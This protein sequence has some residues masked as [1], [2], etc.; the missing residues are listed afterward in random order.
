MVDSSR[1]LARAI[2]IATIAIAVAACSKDSTSSTS[3]SI[4]GHVTIN[5]GDARIPAENLVGAHRS[6]LLGALAS[7]RGKESLRINVIF[8]QEALGSGR[9]GAMSVRTMGRAREVADNIRARLAAHPSASQF[10]VSDVSPAIGA[11]RLRVRDASQ[12]DAVMAALRADPAVAS[13]DI[14][15]LVSRG[16]ETRVHLDAALK[17][18]LVREARASATAGAKGFRFAGAGL[19]RIQYWNYNIID[20]PRAWAVPDTGSAAVTVA[21]IDDGINLHPDIA[22]NLDLAGGYDFVSDD[23]QEFGPPVPNCSGGPAF[24]NSDGDGTLGPDSD[25][26]MPI[27]VTFDAQDGCFQVDNIANHGLHVSGTIGATNGSANLVTGVNW[28]VRI[29]MIRALGIDGFGFD[30]DIAQAVLYAAGLPAAGAGGL[31]V[32]APNRAPIINMSL[33]GES[34]STLGAAVAA[35]I[36]AGSVIIASA[37][38]D[39]AST[40]NFPASYPNVI[41]V[42]ALGADGEL[43]SYSTS[44]AFVSL[45]APGGDFRFDIPGAFAGG[46][47]GVLSTVW[48]FV[49]NP[50]F[51]EVAGPDYAFYTGTSMAAPHVSGVAALVLAANPGLTGQ[52]LSDRLTSTAVDMGPP[53]RD[54][55]YGFG[56]VDAYNAITGTQGPAMNVFVSAIDATTGEVA[57]TVQAGSDLSYKLDGLQAGSYY[58][59]AGQ[60]EDGDGVIGFPGRRYGWA[61]GGGV[62]VPVV[63]GANGAVEASIPIGLPVQQLG[64]DGRVFVGSWVYGAL[65]TP[66]AVET[67]VVTIPTSG[68]Y[69]FET[70]GAIGSCGFALELNTAITV[71]DAH[72]TLVGSN[73]NTSSTTGHMTFPGQLCSYVSAQLSPGT[74]TVEVKAGGGSAGG[75]D[76]FNPG[77]YRLQVRSG[78]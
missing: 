73:D 11:A 24:T 14:D 57:K 33:G 46:T 48:D 36:N 59:V 2:S 77:T 43:A 8:R 54:A 69:S 13:V 16:A 4:V 17:Q 51:N 34:D 26:T 65:G 47:S 9:L 32:M 67:Y 53:G 31:T 25:P 10:T 29:R 30:F 40:P 64:V 74:Y 42:A 27:S 7:R 50:L 60:D 23:S 78:A 3:R 68:V 39:G 55:R 41:S 22:P 20:A 66:T 52:Q 21:V 62:P 15:R 70:S 1:S 6:S 45:V 63:V 5:Q 19:S 71:T 37:G 56:R 58:V 76:L 38:N 72:G 44:N 75:A 35:A 49:N 18:Q 61:N 28:N 12:R